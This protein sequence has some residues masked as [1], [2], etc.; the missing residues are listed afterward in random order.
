MLGKK[1]YCVKIWFR[2]FE[3]LIKPFL[4]KKEIGQVMHAVLKK[5]DHDCYLTF[6]GYHTAV[7]C[8][9]FMSVYII[10]LKVS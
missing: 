9:E 5:E 2:V 6:I 3:F 7:I 10:S 4:H 1:L 8:R